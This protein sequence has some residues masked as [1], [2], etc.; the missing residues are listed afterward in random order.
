M[1]KKQVLT[2]VALFCSLLAFAQSDEYTVA[3]DFDSLLYK[4]TSRGK[5]TYYNLS[6]KALDVYS[7]KTGELNVANDSLI[8]KTL[9]STFQIPEGFKGSM[10]TIRLSFL[11]ESGGEISN[12]R[13][14]NAFYAQ[15]KKKEFMPVA[16]AFQRLKPVLVYGK[17][18]R[19]EVIREIVLS[20]PTSI[21][22]ENKSPGYK[23]KE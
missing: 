23:I 19:I 2:I 11:I 6:G 1:I 3:Y 22:R 10:A 5:E 16:P 20:S 13:I 21:E 14:L 4:E 12:F 8:S 17:A 7:N 15:Y 18:V 9:Y